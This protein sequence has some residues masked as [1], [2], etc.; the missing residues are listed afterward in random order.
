MRTGLTLAALA[1]VVL[2]I[3]VVVGFLRGL[4]TMLAKSGDPS[5][6]LVYSVAASENIEASS[7]SSALPGLLDAHTAGIR[8]RFRTPY[9]SP[10]LY[11]GARIT[12]GSQ[13]VG[14]GLV[15][16]VTAQAPLVRSKVQLVEGRWPGTREIIV[17]TLAAAKLGCDPQQLAIGRTLVFERQT[18]NIVGRFSAGGGAFEA[19]IWAPL[20]DLQHALQRQDL[21]LVAL[22]LMPSASPAEVVL[23]CKQRTDLEVQAVTESSYYAAM[24]KHYL[25]VRWMAWS[26]VTLVGAAGVFA[27]M[28]LMFGSVAGRVR[29]LATLQAIGFRRSAILTSLIQEG[30][31]LACVGAIVA[32]LV[33]IVVL[34]GHAVRFTM[35]AFALRIDGPAILIGCGIGLL[36][37][38]IGAVP[39]AIRALRMAV[40]EGLKAI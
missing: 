26:V 31:L 29:E 24:Q 1:V 20:A 34:N 7:I 23:F 38:V 10:E 37:G 17:G 3:F 13:Y 22:T 2:L 15:R 19:E 16:G 6:V 33:S 11:L 25:P 39:P 9:M 12:T 40:V 27:G 32:G 28:N 30:A 36:V 5:V 21:S 18:W 14:L 4:E 8:R 35:G